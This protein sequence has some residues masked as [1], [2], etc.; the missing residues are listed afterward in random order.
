MPINFILLKVSD[1]ADVWR[2]LYD[3]GIL[4]RDFSRAEYLEDCLRVTVGTAEE[5]QAFC[6]ALQEI[7]A[8]RRLEHVKG[9]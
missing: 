5:N 9:K 3:K 8:E 6:G 7:F 2:R 1:A 4:V